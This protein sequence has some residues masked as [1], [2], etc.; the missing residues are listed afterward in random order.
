MK[1]AFGYPP[2]E[3]KRWLVAWS[4]ILIVI[5]ALVSIIAYNF[6]AVM[7]LCS[8]GSVSFQDYDQA[9]YQVYQ[10]NS[11]FSPIE[12]IGTET[13]GSLSYAASNGTAS[14]SIRGEEN[15]IVFL[16][17]SI[18]LSTLSDLSL[19]HQYQS[20]DSMLR[21]V[22]KPHDVLAAEI[23]LLQVAS[24]MTISGGIVKNEPVSFFIGNN[25]LSL[26]LSPDK[27]TLFLQISP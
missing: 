10:P 26:R 22:C 8:K 17:G 3:T 4:A 15:Q 18:H 27:T 13:D 5:L 23:A 9:V 21:V 20:I 2:S 19:L 14:F 7:M 12:H 25:H 16:Q 24:R 1:K 11:E 6:S